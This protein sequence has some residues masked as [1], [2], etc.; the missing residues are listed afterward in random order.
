[1][2]L[3]LRPWDLKTLL[4]KPLKCG[5]RKS[6]LSVWSKI[7]TSN[8]YIKNW[9]HSFLDTLRIMATYLLKSRP[10]WKEKLLHGWKNFIRTIIWDFLSSINSSM[11]IIKSYMRRNKE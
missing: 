2:R 8:H 1:M 5:E 10:G 4:V 6:K 3:Q 7:F 11:K 9:D